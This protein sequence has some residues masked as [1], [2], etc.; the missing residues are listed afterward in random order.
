MNSSL[1]SLMQKKI[2]MLFQVKH[3]DD[4]SSV[5]LSIA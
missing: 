3:Y 1:E 4:A 2:N 5:T